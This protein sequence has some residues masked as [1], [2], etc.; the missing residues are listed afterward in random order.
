MITCQTPKIKVSNF[1][2]ILEEEDKTFILNKTREVL[3]SHRWTVGPVGTAFEEAFKSFTGSSSA[4]AVGD[5]GAAIIAVLQALNI[6]E[7]SLILCPTLTAPPTPHA[8]LAA[9]MKVVFAD[10][11]PDDLGLDPVDVEKKLNQYKNQIKAVITVHVGGWISPRIKEIKKL[12]DRHGIPLIEDCAHAHGSWFEGKHAGSTAGIATY[13]F[14]MTK[15]LTSGEGGIVTAESKELTESIR[16]IRNYGKNDQGVHVIKGFNHKLS[17]FNAVVALWASVNAKR[18]TEER[19]KIAGI[20]DEL[21][22][23][24]P[25]FKI[26][27][28]P[29]CTCSYYKYILVLDP[30]LDRDEIKKTLLHEYGVEVSG[31]VYD[32]L[33][34]QEPYFRTVP[35]EVLNVSDSFPKAEDFS[36]RQIC[37]PL[38]PGLGKAD[39]KLV[40]DSLKN[41]LS[42]KGFRS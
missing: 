21:L 27:K 17:E 12:C 24:V 23:N 4:V 26:V 38:Y 9:N 11:N 35:Q 42:S 14:F 15:P 6:P 32:T 40:V 29:E 16:I 7:G 19:R 5:G 33:C 28:V 39:Q 10:S 41:L 36:R 3:D 37:L 18:L 20:Y 13:S 34:H 25:G 31:G 8:I 1:K 30:K 22:A 2:L